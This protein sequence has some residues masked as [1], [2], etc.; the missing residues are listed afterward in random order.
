VDASFTY[1]P[2]GGVEPVP[3]RGFGLPYSQ[4]VE[5]VSIDGLVLRRCA[6]A[7]V[8][9]AARLL[10][11]RGDASDAAD[12]EAVVADEGCEGTAV[13]VDGERVV[14]TLTLLDEV[15]RVDG[16]DVPAGQ[17]ELVATDPG[18][19]GRGLVRRLMAWGHA[20]SRQRGHLLQVMIGIP[21][22]YR[23]FGYEYAIPMPGWRRLTAAP[24]PPPG[25]AVRRATPADIGAMQALQDRA[26][27]QADVRM[28]HTAA[29]WRRLVERSGSEQWVVERGGE[30]VGVS[31]TLPPGEGA[32]L[33]E[34]AVADDPAALAL[35][36]HAASRVDEVL[37]V[38]QRVGAP[39]VLGAFLA[40]PRDKPD[41]YYGRVE[42]LAP[43]L[44]HLAPVLQARL[45]AAGLGDRDHEVLISTWRA[46]LRFGIGPSG[47]RLI[48]EGG[49]EQ[50]P[51]SKGGS[52][53]PPDAVAS[54]V[55]GPHGAL[56]LEELLADCHLGRQREL[57]AALFPPRTADLLT[58]Y[59]PV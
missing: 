48:A 46:H 41:W 14:S 51:I 47:V 59:L 4:P 39:A 50:A 58:F 23:Q 57:M 44:A 37:V 9:G 45:D 24:P 49:V 56:G 32:A 35:V 52:G 2:A 10:A 16:V 13:V 29:C 55:L 7:D 40:P 21:F 17:V 25:H 18:Y 33:A 30:V 8:A 28:G 27:E 19:E 11:Q 15:V 3:E 1:T 22:F 6:P 36:A 38:Q 31:R 12:L 5:P 43:L 53:L 34:L 54:L 26:Q 20:R 42:R